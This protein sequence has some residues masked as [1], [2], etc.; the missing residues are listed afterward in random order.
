M[1]AL[2]VTLNAF[3]QRKTP[4]QALQVALECMNRARGPNPNSS[5]HPTTHL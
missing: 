2:K 3:I 5:T 4:L 1:A